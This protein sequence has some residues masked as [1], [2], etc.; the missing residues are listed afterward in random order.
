NA[1]AGDGSVVRSITPAAAD[2]FRI[3]VIGFAAALMLLSLTFV[4]GVEIKGARRWINLPG[5]SVQP[6]EFVKPTFAVV[7]AWLFSEQK[8][9][10]GFSGNIISIVLFL[11]IAGML[12][13]QPD[14]GI[15]AVVA[16]VW[17]APFFMAGLR[18]CC[19]L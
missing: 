15:A 7:A 9:R 12:I 2:D 16:I 1:A 3:A 6:S 10:P 18:T 5:L 19:G 17:F 11:T 4:I 14:T 13:K 8:L